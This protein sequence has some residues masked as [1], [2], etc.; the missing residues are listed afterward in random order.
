MSMSEAVAAGADA[1]FDEKY[2]EQV[3]VV[4][5]EGYSRE[6]CGGTHC[7]A[8][9]QIGS[10]VLFSD[11]SIGSGMRRIEAL[12][13]EAADAHIR[14]RLAALERVTDALGSADPSEAAERVIELQAKVREL[15]R[16]LKAG[17]RGPRPGELARGA[18]EIAPGVRLVAASVDVAS[19]DELKALARDVRGALG[20]G[21]VALA[22]DVDE[23]QLFVT[24]SEDLAARGLSAADLVAAAAPSL[25]GRGGGRPEMAQAKGTRRA[26]V[27]DALA[28][29]R[30]AAR[31]ALRQPEGSA[32]R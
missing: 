11:R 1:F 6:L 25:G 32:P 2:G 13:G 9:G 19:L 24:V 5:V 7:E 17:A 20:N 30:S 16:R 23:P 31:A 8:S 29:L 4:E 26:G 3:R 27:S 21:I 12:T 18:E 10:F 28:A 15:E 14:Q 22:L